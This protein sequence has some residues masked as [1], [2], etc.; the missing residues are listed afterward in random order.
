[1]SFEYILP[2]GGAAG[3]PLMRVIKSAKRQ[4]VERTQSAPALH[5]SS[6]STC[7][8][9]SDGITSVG[10]NDSHLHGHGHSRLGDFSHSGR[11]TNTTPSSPAAYDV[12]AS[13]WDR[14]QTS[15]SQKRSI[16]SPC[17]ICHRRP[18]LRTEIDS[19]ADCEGCGERTCWI[20]IRECAGYTPLH[21]KVGGTIERAREGWGGGGSGQHGHRRMVC[22]Q[23][24]VEK[25]SEG[26][27]WCLGCLR[28]EDDAMG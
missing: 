16:T 6:T 10:K 28:D 8:P 1:M 23:C 5:L 7:T 4:R 14:E 11:Q 3:V 27:V 24:C 13:L 2:G 26:E 25:G 17:H 22:S 20:C 19:Y 15:G 9:Q 12:S 21:M 18:T